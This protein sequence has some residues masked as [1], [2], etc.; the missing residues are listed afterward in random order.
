MPMNNPPHPGRILGQDC[1]EALDLS[2]TEGAKRLGVSRTTLSRVIN[3][4][5]GISADMAIRLEKMGWSTAGQ[6]LR[7]QAAYDLARARQ[8]QD[9][10]KVE[11]CEWG[12][13]RRAP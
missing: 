11:R 6:W 4:K 8:H 3:G 13:E 1:L 9:D 7:L 5:A 10:I 12:I 2:V